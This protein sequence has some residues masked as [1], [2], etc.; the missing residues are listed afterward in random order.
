MPKSMYEDAQK[1]ILVNSIA[2]EQY[3]NHYCNVTGY[4]TTPGCM[5]RMKFR[6]PSGKE[7]VRPISVYT[8][9]VSGEHA[10]HCPVRYGVYDGEEK[11]K[12]HFRNMNWEKLHALLNDPK[13]KVKNS[14][15]GGKSG[16]G[17]HYSNNDPSIRSVTDLYC[18]CKQD[19]GYLGSV[20]TAALILDCNT[21]DTA[22]AG[23]T[24]RGLHVVELVA[25]KWFFDFDHQE[26]YFRINGSNPHVFLRVS[27]ADR[28]LFFNMKQQIGTKENLKDRLMI[29][30][31]EIEEDCAE[32]FHVT[33]QKYQGATYYHM[34]ISDRKWFRV[35]KAKSNK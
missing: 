13:R 34:N 28:N 6:Y 17:Q 26:F 3:K 27:V 21:I 31:G 18:A 1:T 15:S 2:A 10:E 35:L 20:S 7:G 29:A 14:N 5:A 8:S 33:H 24:I 11:N 23:G 9:T 22:S 30:F 4:C 32:H 16:S 12:H 25:E 19:A